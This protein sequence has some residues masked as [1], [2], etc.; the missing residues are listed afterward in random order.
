M[1]DFLHLGLSQFQ[2]H[3]IESDPQRPTHGTRLLETRAASTALAKARPCCL[4]H[5]IVRRGV[6]F[7]SAP[8]P[9]MNIAVVPGCVSSTYSWANPA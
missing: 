9:I 2:R 7:W 5:S 4:A 3:F 6:G 1:F 8:Q